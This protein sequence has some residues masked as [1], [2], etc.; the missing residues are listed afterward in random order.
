MQKRFKWKLQKFRKM[1][2]YVNKEYHLFL[3]KKKTKLSI[4]L[5]NEKFK[6]GVTNSKNNQIENWESH[7]FKVEKTT[8]FLGF[9]LTLP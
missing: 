3:V 1:E 5:K 9:N 2:S 4:T 8:N 7:Y 6:K